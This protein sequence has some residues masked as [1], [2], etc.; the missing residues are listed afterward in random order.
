MGATQQKLTP[1]TPEERKI[2]DIKP[3]QNGYIGSDGA[4]VFTQKE[5]T[6]AQLNAAVRADEMEPLVSEVNEM[7][8]DRDYRSVQAVSEGILG[9]IGPVGNML[10]SAPTQVIRQ[11]INRIVEIYGR[12]ASGGVIGVPERREMARNLTPNVGDTKAAILSKMNT[13]NNLVSG[14][15]KKSAG[16]SGTNEVNWEDL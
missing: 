10:M 1:F 12:D 2:W 3:G 9:M 4:P 7:A 16:T 13:L 6:S 15:K 5:V 11:K 14:F 8:K